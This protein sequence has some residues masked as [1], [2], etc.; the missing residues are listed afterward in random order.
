MAKHLTHAYGSAAF[1]VCELMKP[2]ARTTSKTGIANGFQH[3]GAPIV[4]NYPFVEAEVEYVQRELDRNPDLHNLHEVAMRSLQ[5]VKKTRAAA[6]RASVERARLLPK[7]LGIHPLIAHK[8]NVLAENQ[9]A[10]FLTDLK[11]FKPAAAT[12]AIDG[13]AF[14]RKSDVAAKRRAAAAMA[15]SESAAV[16]DNQIEED[17]DES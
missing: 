8:V 15:A 7:A 2:I 14:V 13:G 1:A 12:T 9:R 16:L 11:S 10:A 17:D 3:F 5:M 6:S 4:P